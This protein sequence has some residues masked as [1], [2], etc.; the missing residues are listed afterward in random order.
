MFTEA[1][2][3]MDLPET[4]AGVAAAKL[5]NMDLKTMCKLGKQAPNLSTADGEGPDIMK[6]LNS[7]ILGDLGL[8]K[9][10]VSTIGAYGKAIYDPAV[11]KLIEAATAA[12]KAYK[13]S[14]CGAS[15]DR[16]DGHVQACR[17]ACKLTQSSCVDVPNIIDC[18]ALFATCDATCDA[19]GGG[20]GAT[21]IGG[22]VGDALGELG[23]AVGDAL[24]ELGEL[25]DAAGNALGNALGELGELGE[26]G[27]LGEGGDPFD[28]VNCDDIPAGLLTLI[29]S[30]ESEM[31]AMFDE[32]FS[33][34]FLP[35]DVADV[36][37]AK[38]KN[39]DA[40]TM[41]KLGKQAPN[42]STADGEGP[43]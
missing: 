11:K 29:S 21:N 25:G 43:D 10:T 40:T 13:D 15:R 14:G 28:G 17:D 6:I 32:A 42:L 39:I 41:C 8:D 31:D 18:S 12:E 30:F 24:G 22:V 23:D 5:K 27:K 38:L 34:V 33:K 16:R 7:G 2:S 9:S 37:H 19:M 36:A 4:V 1:F 20:G 3:D 35:K 26:L